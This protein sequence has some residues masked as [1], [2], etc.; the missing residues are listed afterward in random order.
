MRP[1]KVRYVEFCFRRCA[2][3]PL[4]RVISNGTAAVPLDI[5]R[6]KGSHASK[7]KRELDA[8][9]VAFKAKLKP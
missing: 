7:I 6:V 2:C 8:H 1:N 9:E 5:T 3:E 4:I